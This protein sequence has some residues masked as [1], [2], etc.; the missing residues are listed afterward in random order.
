MYEKCV[1]IGNVKC[2]RTTPKLPIKDRA[3]DLDNLGQRKKKLSRE[4]RT[5]PKSQQ[6]RVVLFL[7]H[8]GCMCGGFSGALLTQ[9]P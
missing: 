1:E 5:K 6:K 3:I 4:V 9:T 7:A 2:Q 8:C